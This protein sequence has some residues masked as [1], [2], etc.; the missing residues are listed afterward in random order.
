VIET[1]IRPTKSLKVQMN[2]LWFA[3]S[4]VFA[5]AIRDIKIRYTQTFLGWIWMFVNPLVNLVVLVV[6]FSKIIQLEVKGYDYTIFV[7][8]GLL[9]WNYFSTVIADVGNII[10]N[11]RDLIKKVFFPKITIILSRLVVGSIE[12]FTTTIVLIVIMIYKSLLP[13]SN[14][15][16]IFLPI[17][18]TIFFTLGVALWVGAF[19]YRFR[20]IVHAVPIILRV[21]MFL[22][23]IGWS[24][25]NTD[26]NWV[27]FNPLVMCIELFRWCLLPDYALTIS[28]IPSIIIIFSLVFSGFLVFAK[29]EQTIADHL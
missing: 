25:T 26:V 13:P 14:A 24:M 20:D 22:S 10:L 17:L 1:I 4:L 2:E 29:I 9:S 6:L 5:M 11:S 28:V 12:F 19:V 21:L 3:K 18:A 16:F 15:I 23:P 27:Q 7:I 8:A